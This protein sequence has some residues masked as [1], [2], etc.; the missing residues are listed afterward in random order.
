[1]NAYHGDKPAISPTSSIEDLQRHVRWM[2]DVKGFTTD[3]LP[4]TVL[5]ME[6]VGELAQEI[7]RI[8]RLARA[9]GYTAEAWKSACLERRPSVRTEMADCLIA[10]LKLANYCEIDLGGRSWRRRIPCCAGSGRTCPAM[11][12]PRPAYAERSDRR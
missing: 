10:L 9:Q 8:H 2:D 12:R 11:A 4:N 7:H 6:E 5:L 1:M 3:I